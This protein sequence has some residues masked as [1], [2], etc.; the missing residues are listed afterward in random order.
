VGVSNPVLGAVPDVQNLDR[1]FLYTVDGDVWQGEKNQF[2]GAFFAPDTATPRKTDQL[3][4][5]L[6]DSA[7]GFPC[8]FR[9]VFSNAEADLFE[10]GTGLRSPSDFH[11]GFSLASQ[12]PL[13]LGFHIVVVHQF[14]PVGL[15]DTT[16]D[17]GAKLQIFF[18]HSQGRILHQFFGVGTAIAGDS[19]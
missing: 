9:F 12:K 15:S 17:V 6:K 7:N 1:G 11:F 14:A 3:L 5:A 16:T 4:D 18:D 8:S 13:D 2:P 19:P 10:V